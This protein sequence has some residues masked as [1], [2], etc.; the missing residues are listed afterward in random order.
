MVGR[1]TKKHVKAGITE[2]LW[3]TPI[4]TMVLPLTRHECMSFHWR[5]RPGNWNEQQGLSE[6][7]GEAAREG[8]GIA[9]G[10]PGPAVYPLLHPH[11]HHSP[12]CVPT[13]TDQVRASPRPCSLPFLGP[14][15]WLLSWPHPNP[16]PFPSAGGEGGCSASWTEWREAALPPGRNGSRAESGNSSSQGALGDSVRF[17]PGERRWGVFP[18]RFRGQWGGGQ[19]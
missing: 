6:P 9:S 16:T 14:L 17:P 4:E 15:G 11:Q 2:P 3:T 10:I 1:R 19:G 13:A 12:D 18:G 8:R 5:E 7:G